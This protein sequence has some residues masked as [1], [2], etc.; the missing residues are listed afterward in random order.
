MRVIR[1]GNSTKS[2]FFSKFLLD[3][4]ENNL[5]IERIDNTDIIRIPHDLLIHNDLPNTPETLKNVIFP[6]IFPL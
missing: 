6:N 4:G 3:A 5:I 1:N 2:I